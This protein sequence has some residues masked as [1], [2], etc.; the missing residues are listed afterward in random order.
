MSGKSGD[1][2]SGRR[3]GTNFKLEVED[4]GHSTE[5]PRMEE[6]RD[7]GSKG[8]VRDVM[9]VGYRLSVRV[10]TADSK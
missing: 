2:C 6:V 9:V 7:Q 8:T 3:G 4:S 10:Q 5:G 1:T